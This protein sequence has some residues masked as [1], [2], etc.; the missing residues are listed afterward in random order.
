MP[1]HGLA[2]RANDL[3][4][5]YRDRLRLGEHPGNRVLHRLAALGLLALADVYDGADQAGERAVAARVGRLV[6][7][8]VAPHADGCLNDRLVGLAAWPLPQRLVERVQA[9]RNRLVSR[10]QIG[11]RLPDELAA[12]D[13]EETLPRLVDAAVTPIG[14][15]EI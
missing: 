10:I 6:I 1:A 7:Q 3:G 14:A 2:D 9:F 13:A 11:N 4:H 8:H 5:R 15:F 12:G